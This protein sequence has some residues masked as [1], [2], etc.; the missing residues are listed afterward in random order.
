M[1]KSEFAYL[2]SNKQLDQEK[3]LQKIPKMS[4]QIEVII[5]KN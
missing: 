1:I 3:S 4:V 2:C 5:V